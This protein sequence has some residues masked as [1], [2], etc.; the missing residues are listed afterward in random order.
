M[1][2]EV[3]VGHLVGVG[4]LAV[5]A[6]LSFAMSPLALG[7]TSTLALVLVA[8]WETIVRVRRGPED[9]DAG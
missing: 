9:A 2:R 8:S 1:A 6:A 7:A 5:V 4:A 3:L